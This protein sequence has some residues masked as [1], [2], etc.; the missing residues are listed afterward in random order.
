MAACSASLELT[1][2]ELKGMETLSFSAPAREGHDDYLMSL[3][4][5][6]YAAATTPPPESQVIPPGWV[7]A[8]WGED[9]ARVW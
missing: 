5:C 1:R 3:A 4:L 8:P 6:V 9:W 2:Y 7:S